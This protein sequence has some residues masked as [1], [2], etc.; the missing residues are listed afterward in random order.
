[1]LLRNAVLK[2][3][4]NTAAKRGEAGSLRKQ[5]IRGEGLL[6]FAVS[7]VECIIFKTVLNKN[8]VF[9]LKK[10]KEQITRRNDSRILIM[11][12]SEYW[13]HR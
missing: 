4:G 1:M 7:L 3:R 8:I 11:I 9:H 5:K 2:T 6:L 10:E 13:V 12:I